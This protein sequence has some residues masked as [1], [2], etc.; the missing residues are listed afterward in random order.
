MNSNVLFRS[1]L[2]Q[3][4]A[5]VAR[6]QSRPPIAFSVARKRDS[7][8]GRE[9]DLLTLPSPSAGSPLLQFPPSQRFEHRNFS[10][11]VAV[12]TNEIHEGYEDDDLAEIRQNVMQ[13][14]INPD[15]EEG[16]DESY[17]SS[18]SVGHLDSTATSFQSMISSRRTI[19]NFLHLN[20]DL[21]P[22]LD[23]AI[24]CAQSV[25]THKR[26]EPFTFKRLLSRSVIAELSE[27]AYQVTFQRRLLKDPDGAKNF[28]ER[29]KLKWATQAP[30]YL[31]TLVRDQPNQEPAENGDIGPYEELPFIPPATERQL[32]DVRIQDI[33]WTQLNP[34]HLSSSLT[35]NFCDLQYAT[36]CA[37]VQNI[38][39][40]LQAE[41]IG[42]KGATGPII[43]TRAFRE[44]IG[45][46]STDRIV[47]MIM[48]GYPRA[49]REKMRRTATED[50]VQDL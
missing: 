11:S 3:Q 24:V 36:S 46:K 34:K 27:I 4:F 22:A 42:T 35:S 39:L 43:K 29:K 18:T 23:R 12:A 6:S 14:E 21:K 1:H 13:L 50:I 47:A 41:N 15:R 45:A 37:A 40:S 16:H 33:Y 38:L 32:E 17:A 9:Q 44:L 49:P 31:V 5:N 20:I 30:A 2:M 28:A 19:S 8:L 25:P 7:N 26:T 10:S 48:V